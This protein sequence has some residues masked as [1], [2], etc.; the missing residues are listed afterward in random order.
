MALL[1]NLVTERAEWTSHYRTR[2]AR[3]S[4]V[5][6]LT[7][8]SLLLVVGLMLYLYPEKVVALFRTVFPF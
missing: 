4:Q 1:S 2:M 3:R 6:A 5:R 8:F 7:E